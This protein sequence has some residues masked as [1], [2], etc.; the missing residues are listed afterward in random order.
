[1]LLLDEQY[2]LTP[3]YGYGKMQ[4]VLAQAGYRVNHKRVRK[5]M[6]IVAGPP[7]R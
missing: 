6:Q 1:M 2:V 4:L 5:L 7:V 3:Y